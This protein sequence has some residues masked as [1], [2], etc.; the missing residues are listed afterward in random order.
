[1]S[2]Y[3]VDTFTVTLSGTTWLHVECSEGRV[4]D[5]R[6]SPVSGVHTSR[7]GVIPKESPP[8]QWRLIV[9]LLTLEGASTNDVIEIADVRT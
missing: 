3:P 5:T 4:L 2:N 6:S 8:G 9:N 7:F 1:M